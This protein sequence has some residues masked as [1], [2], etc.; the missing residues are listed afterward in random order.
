[1]TLPTGF[2]LY[3]ANAKVN[4]MQSV[5]SLI[6]CI[7]VMLVADS[8]GGAILVILI[9]LYSFSARIFRLRL[10]YLAAAIPVVGLLLL[11]LRYV[12]REAWRYNTLGEFISDKGGILAVFF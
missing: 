7:F 10:A 1:M 4:S 2:A 12:S 11:Y 5:L 3:I 8:R 9:Y 6:S